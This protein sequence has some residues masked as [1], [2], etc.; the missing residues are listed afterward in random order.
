M[1]EPRR[2]TEKGREHMHDGIRVELE[3]PHDA[4]AFAEFLAARG[5]TASIT[6]ENDHCELEIR[7]A[8]DPEAR[9]RPEFEAAL[10]SWVE[11]QERPLVPAFNREHHYVLRPPGD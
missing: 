7:Y 6:S 2:Q 5:L 1:D 8:V 3:C 9:L 10:A 11:Q 4:A